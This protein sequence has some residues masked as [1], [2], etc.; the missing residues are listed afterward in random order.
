MNV[1]DFPAVALAD[2]VA[3]LANTPMF[4]A[5]AMAQVPAQR[6][7]RQPAPGQFSLVEHACHLRDLEREGYLVRLR[8]M[9]AERE[10]ALEGFDGTAVAAQRDYMAQDAR[11]AAQEFAAARRELTGL[12]APLTQADLDRRGTFAGEPVTLAAVIEMMVEH[13]REHRAEIEALLDRV[14]D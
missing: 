11:I 9:L 8:R 6:W 14:E 1:A 3:I 4:L 7:A 10:P 5:E 13:D 2:S 12:L